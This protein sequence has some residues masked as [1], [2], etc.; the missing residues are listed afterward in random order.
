L[1]RCISITEKIF[2]DARI[3]KEVE[4]EKVQ[5]LETQKREVLEILKKHIHKK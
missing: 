4:V 5:G 3:T 2:E 1:E